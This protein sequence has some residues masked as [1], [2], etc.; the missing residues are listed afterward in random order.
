MM[1]GGAVDIEQLESFLPLIDSSHPVGVAESVYEAFESLVDT[2]EAARPLEFVRSFQTGP[3]SYALA[4]LHYY[5]PGF[6]TLP[7][8][9]RRS[10]LVGCCERINKAI[11]AT[12]QLTGFLEYGAPNRDQRPA[13]EDPH[14]DVEAA[15]LRDVEKESYRRIAEHLRIGI[16]EKAR[17]VGD[18]STVAKM[19]TRGRDILERAFRRD[20]WKHVAAE[21]RAERVRRSE[22][23]KLEKYVEDC[24]E[25]WRIGQGA[26]QNILEG[27]DPAP[28]TKERIGHLGLRLESIRRFYRALAEEGEGD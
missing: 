22:L 23:S 28:K 11:A 9:E 25:D 27:V 24:A 15:V 20:G 18:Y 12:R 2:G 10:L 16:S 5:R 8:E 19:A 13:V 26:A 14:R 21:M 3:V 7:E 1:E 17:H 6:D 4:L